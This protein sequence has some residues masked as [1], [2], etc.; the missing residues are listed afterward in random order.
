MK[1][2]DFKYRNDYGHDL[3]L[4]L[5][6]TKRYSLFQLCLSWSE[7]AGWPFLQVHFGNGRLI[8]SLF[9]V[10]KF[11]W[12]FDIIGRTWYWENESN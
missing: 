2:I 6:K 4:Y 1:L 12:D 7:Y 3:Y 10:Y 8:G 9:W 11:G 5:F